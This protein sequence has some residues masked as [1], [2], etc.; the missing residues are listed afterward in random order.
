MNTNA[1]IYVDKETMD[2]FELYNINQQAMLDAELV[3]NFLDMAL[4]EETPDILKS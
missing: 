1:V 4:D 2:A 3:G